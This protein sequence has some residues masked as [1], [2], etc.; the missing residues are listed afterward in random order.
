YF[1][2]AYY[3]ENASRLK[4]VGVDSG[5]GC[6]TPSAQ[7]I[8]DGSYMPLSRPLL[9]YVNRASL[10]RPEVREFVAFYLATAPE[11]SEQVGYVPLDAATYQQAEATLSAAVNE[12]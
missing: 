5:S 2:F 12:S 4:V 6:V 7:T 8:V 11:L 10:E 3:A 1:G 9:I